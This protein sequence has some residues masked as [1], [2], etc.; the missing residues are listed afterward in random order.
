[1]LQFPSFEAFKQEVM[2]VFPLRPK[3][4]S[5]IIQTNLNGAAALDACPMDKSLTPKQFQEMMDD[6]AVIIDDI[7]LTDDGGVVDATDGDYAIEGSD[8]LAIR[9]VEGVP[10]TRADGKWTLTFRTTGE[11]AKTLRARDL[12]V[13]GAYQVLENLKQRG[14]ACYL[15]S[16]T[17]HEYVVE[18]SAVVV[19][20]L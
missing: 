5:H 2:S 4:F 18:E 12:V 11:V 8:G 6:G 7:L 19:V 14:L 13:P 16:G 15:A 17:D 10:Y 1:M 20:V 3:S 9:V